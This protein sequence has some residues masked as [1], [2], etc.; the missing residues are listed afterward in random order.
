MACNSVFVKTNCIGFTIGVYNI[1]SI[2]LI[3][4]NTMSDKVKVS[5]SNIDG[6][7]IHNSVSGTVSIL[8][9]KTMFTFSFCIERSL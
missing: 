9:N 4:D 7:F 8:M 6:T 1:T 5:H 2:M 3:N